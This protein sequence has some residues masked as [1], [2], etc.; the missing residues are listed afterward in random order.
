MAC[1]GSRESIRRSVSPSLLA[2]RRSISPPKP[3]T[4]VTSSAR[5]A[6]PPM[7]SA[8]NDCGRVITVGS[9]TGTPYPKFPRSQ[10]PESGGGSI[11]MTALLLD[12]PDD[13]ERMMAAAD[14]D[15]VERDRETEED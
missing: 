7:D 11:T 15:D 3:I 9:T 2:S 14:E 6:L 8:V 4:N 13:D 12:S 1:S 5:S 10:K